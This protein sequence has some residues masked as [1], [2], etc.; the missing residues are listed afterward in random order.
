MLLDCKIIID[1]QPKDILDLQEINISLSLSVLQ[2][3]KTGK[4]LQVLETNQNSLDLT[5]KTGKVHFFNKDKNQIEVLG[6]ESG[7]FFNLKEIILN[8]K[9]NQFL[10]KVESNLE[11]TYFYENNQTDDS[12]VLNLE[13]ILTKNHNTELSKLYQNFSL[14]SQQI[15]LEGLA[16][17]TNS[18]VKKIKLK[19][20][21]V[22]TIESLVLIL[23]KEGLKMRDVFE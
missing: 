6:L 8:T 4:V 14:F 5:L 16:N 11:K 15:I 7:E 13:K 12:S 17:N 2:E 21:A 3:F 1:N 19:N 20:T 22:K 18:S 9:I 23:K 10:Y